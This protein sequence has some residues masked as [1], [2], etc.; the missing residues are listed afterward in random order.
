MVYPLLALCIV[1]VLWPVP[2]PGQED[3]LCVRRPVLTCLAVGDDLVDCDSPCGVLGEMNENCEINP[4][5]F[6]SRS[7]WMRLWGNEHG[8]CPAY[9]NIMNRA[10]E[11]CQAL[12]KVDCNGCP[13]CL[14][15][16]NSDSS[17][18]EVL[19]QG[20]FHPDCN[21]E[22]ATR[23]NDYD[24]GSIIDLSRMK[25]VCFDSSSAANSCGVSPNDPVGYWSYVVTPFDVSLRIISES[26]YNSNIYTI[27]VFQDNLSRPGQ[28]ECLTYSPN[29]IQDPGSSSPEIA[30]V[31]QANRGIY[32]LVSVSEPV[33][34]SHLQEPHYQV[35]N[36][37]FELNLSIRGANPD[38][39]C[40]M[41]CAKPENPNCTCTDQ[42]GG[43]VMARNTRSCEWC[44]KFPNETEFCALESL[45]SLYDVDGFGPLRSRL[46]FHYSPE[47][48]N[49]ETVCAHFPMS[50]Y[51]VTAS[52]FSKGGQVCMQT[53][54]NP[55]CWLPDAFNCSELVPGAVFDLCHTDGYE[56][57]FRVFVPH[58][59]SDVWE[60]FENRP[61]RCYNEEVPTYSSL[62][63]SSPSTHATADKDSAPENKSVARVLFAFF[64]TLEGVVVF[65]S[66]LVMLFVI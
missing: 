58:L 53:S 19:L 7:F 54:A 37:T 21:L 38:S 48:F 47:Y 8:Q 32:V 10:Q 45:E 42:D 66:V 26:S 18:S 1:I 35:Y 6:R 46:C 29:N 56:G 2:V 50:R 16:A 33:L 57:P 44:F 63:T 22:F 34:L 51:S 4:G 15:L 30:F 31:V 62:P 9:T 55:S 23:P 43:L 39:G 65:G 24:S 17:R 61:G 11:Q 36:N 13:D 3:G 41:Y 40:K 60:D 25:D 5:F 20:P 49:G 28:L 52:A 12:S 59:F 27:S 64:T 14:W